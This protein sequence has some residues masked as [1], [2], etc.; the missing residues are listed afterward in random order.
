MGIL[1]LLRNKNKAIK[2]MYDNIATTG[3]ERHRISK[4]IISEFKNSDYPLDKLACGLA[5]INEGAAYRKQA[6]ECIEFYFSHNN[7]EM[8]VNHNNFPY[9][10]EWTLHSELSK[11]Y[12]K[13]YIFDKAIQQ[14]EFC[15][16]CDRSEPN[17]SDYTRIADL[18]VK[19]SDV[20]TA[21]RFLDSL[22]DLPFYVKIK[23]GV[24][25]K[26]KELLDKKKKGYVYKPRKRK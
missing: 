21:I 10:S 1:S 24:E 23:Y 3:E 6:I 2:I 20:E 8:P 17:C 9:F 5:Y 18:L 26:Y 15:I 19:E 7:V 22:K 14:L 13:E 4:N 11:L 12:E 16:Q 25:N